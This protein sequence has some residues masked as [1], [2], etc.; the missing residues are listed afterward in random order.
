MRSPQFRCSATLLHG[1]P[2]RPVLS[3]RQNWAA[4]YESTKTS[5]NCTPLL[6]GLVPTYVHT[7]QTQGLPCH[8]R[9]QP[10]ASENSK[11]SPSPPS[12]PHSCHP[13]CANT[14]TDEPQ[15]PHPGDKHC[16]QLAAAG[17]L[18]KFRGRPRLGF[19]P[20][21]TLLQAP[22]PAKW[23]G[24]RRPSE[25]EGLRAASLW[26]LQAHVEDARTRKGKSEANVTRK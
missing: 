20:T 25:A 3:Q 14:S 10:K 1:G 23:Q 11:S 24:A 4:G 7:R 8:A 15:P 13:S 19:C 16:A 9:Q 6:R 5:L 21:P 26:E 2:S 12:H 22:G 17:H 18:R